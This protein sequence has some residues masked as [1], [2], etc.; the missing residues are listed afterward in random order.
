MDTIV[1]TSRLLLRYQC[2][3][4]VPFLTDLWSDEAV[5]RYLGGPRERDWLRMVFEETAANPTAEKYDLWPLVEKSSGKL[6]GHCGLLEKEIEGESL[7]ELNYMLHP[8]A[9][10]EGYATEIGKALV[11]YAFEDCGLGNL[12]ALIHPENTPSEL[13][14]QRIG[15]YFSGEVIRPGGAV[16]KLYRFDNLSE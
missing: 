12:V 16:R 3:A 7:V 14:A 11:Q 6:V 1:E 13:T 5:T 4:D 15:M 2:A 8:S 9:W 10:G